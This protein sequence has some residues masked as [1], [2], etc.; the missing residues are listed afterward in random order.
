VEYLLD[1]PKK[2]ILARLNLTLFEWVIENLCKNATD[3]IKEKGKVIIHAVETQKGI[4]IDVEDTG[5]GISKSKFKTIFK[6]GYTTKLR[7]WGLGLSLSR[8]I[9]E[10]YHNGRI[11]VLS[12]V[13]YDSTVIRIMLNK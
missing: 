4:I 7:G 5:K 11:F 1:L 3:S 6:P 12:S 9:I 10:S 13:P 2:P 8:R